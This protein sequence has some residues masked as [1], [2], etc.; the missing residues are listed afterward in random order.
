MVDYVCLLCASRL[1]VHW[2]IVLVGCR[3]L[4]LSQ[5]KSEQ[6]TFL[7]ISRSRPLLGLLK[8]SYCNDKKQPYSYKMLNSFLHRPSVLLWSNK[9]FVYAS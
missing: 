9:D 3:Q 6:V 1:Y 2:I 5:T 4:V 8:M 7:Q